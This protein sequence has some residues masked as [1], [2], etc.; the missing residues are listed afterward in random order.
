MTHYG[1]RE[2]A[3]SQYTASVFLAHTLG[4]LAKGCAVE[5]ITE[6]GR[7]TYLNIRRPDLAN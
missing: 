3:P 2:L 7:L 4:R 6:P 1:H 5:P